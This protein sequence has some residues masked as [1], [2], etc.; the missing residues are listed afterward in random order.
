MKKWTYLRTCLIRTEEDPKLIIAWAVAQR[1][2]M[3]RERQGLRQEDIAEKARIKTLNIARLERGKHLPS[4]T[5]L[6]KVAQ[7]LK[8][9][10]TD[11]MAMP[12]SSEEDMIEFS[13][14]AEAGLRE[15]HS[16]LKE[17]DGKK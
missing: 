4:V 10:L 12:T 6:Q 1:V 14:M 17:E 3:E 15:W 8:L 2:R 16:Q 5:T 13:E 7:T 11:L 9:D